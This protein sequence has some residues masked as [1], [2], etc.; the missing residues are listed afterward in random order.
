MWIFW[1]VGLIDVWV[2]ECGVL[3]E[4]GGGVVGGG[5]LRKMCY[6]LHV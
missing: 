5:G 6:V 1:C 3:W 2:V 4:G